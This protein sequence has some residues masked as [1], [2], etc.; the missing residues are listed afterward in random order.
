M[1]IL[2]SKLRDRVGYLQHVDRIC[3]G[4]SVQVHRSAAARF[5]RLRRPGRDLD[6]RRQKHFAGIVGDR[7]FRVASAAW[8][9]LQRVSQARR[10]AS[11]CR[12]AMVIA[13]KPEAATLDAGSCALG[14]CTRDRQAF[15]SPCL[16]HA[17]REMWR[18][19]A[20][21]R[22]RN[23]AGGPRGRLAP[24]PDMYMKAAIS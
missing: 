10:D 3:A 1:V 15:V 5:P 18:P 17:G 13:G 24:S 2:W 9:R 21:T 6:C 20:I 22:R 8:L 14:P 12:R 4:N 7:G 11:S 23:R 16:L 19:E